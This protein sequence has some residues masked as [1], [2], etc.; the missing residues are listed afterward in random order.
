MLREQALAAARTCGLADEHVRM[1]GFDDQALDTIRIHD[2]VLAIR[3]EIVAFEPDCLLG[4]HG[5]DY[6]VD[7][8]ACAKACL[9]ATRPS[10]GE[11]FPARFGTFEVLSSTERAFG[12][13]E[14]FVPNLYVDV[15]EDLPV[16]LA[17]MA[18]YRHELREPPHPRSLDGVRAKARLRGL[19]VGLD[20]AEAFHIV[21]DIVSRWM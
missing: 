6:N 13:R 4:H 12:T 18:E 14:P 1:L 3:A 5:G 9:F 7:H 20:Y 8:Q 19:E 11:V 10:P 16:K 2:L 17:A 15:A 21:R